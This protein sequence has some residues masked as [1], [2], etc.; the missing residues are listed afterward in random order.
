MP[1]EVECDWCGKTFEKYSSQV[2]EHNFCSQECQ[3]K[4]MSQNWEGEN[5]PV[6]KGGKIQTKCDYCGEQI[7]VERYKMEKLNHHFCDKSCFDEW[8]KNKEIV[9]C[10]NCG[11]EFEKIPSKIE[12]KD[13]HFCSRSCYREW[14]SKEVRGKNHPGWNR[15]EISCENCGKVIDRLPSEVEAR[16]HNFCSRECLNEWKKNQ[17]IEVECQ[18]CG[19]KFEKIPFRARKAEN[20]FCSKECRIEWSKGE[21]HPNWKGGYNPLYPPNWLEQRKKAIERDNHLCQLCG[22]EEESIE[23]NVHH[24]VPYIAFDEGKEAN[25]LSNLITLCD[26]CHNRAEYGEITEEELR[27]LAQT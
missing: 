20:H 2:A 4:W 17:R 22:A 19:R 8:Q 5:N 15:I 24:I 14:R 25:R 13:H 7:E 23:H 3:E 16:E 27:K 21:N 6:W 18:N 10:E 11:K 12:R 1:V 26:S 9:E